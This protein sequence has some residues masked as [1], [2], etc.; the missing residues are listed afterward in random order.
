MRTN[1]WKA[2][3][4]A[5]LGVVCILPFAA[6]V[7]LGQ[8][9]VNLTAGATTVT[10]PDGSVVPMWGYTCGTVALT[11]PGCRPLNL[12]APAAT[13]TTPAGWSPV[14]I[15]VPYV[16]TGTSLTIN[17]T[18][19]LTFTGGGIPTSLVIVGQLGAG[20]G[21]LTQRTTT[22]APDHTNAQQ[23]TWP[24]ADP[25]ALGTPP[26]QGPRVQSFSTE[27]AAGA[28]GVP[29]TWSNLKPGTYLIES[30]THPSI[31]GPMGLYGILVV[32]TAPAGATA[33]TAYP[34]VG[35]TVPAVTYSAEVPLLLSE[36]DPLQNNAVAKAVTLP[37]FSETTVWSGQP[38]GCGNP[39][40]TNSGNCYP[41]AVNY[42]PLYYLFNGV[43]FNKTIATSTNPSLF[44]TLP[45]TGL[46]AGTGTVLVRFVNAGLR[47][48]VPSIVGTQTGVAVAPATTPPSGF[49]LIAEDG[50]PLPGV[51]RVQSEVFLPAG[52]T[53]D[54]MINVPATGAASLPVYDRELSL[55]GNA[56]ARDAGMLAYISVNGA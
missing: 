30:G 25:T 11:G 29:L 14:V 44:P 1:N 43:A 51:P 3:L 23:T 46:T 21:D 50:N 9:T 26:R 38:G 6:V 7:A 45:A 5:A 19:S 28:T 47:M 2:I 4:K 42:T 49:S 53:Y 16:A 39:A 37:G 34:A 27:V 56:T 8:Q 20:L 48:H 10:L 15:T 31:Q 22:L 17:L 41:P 55:S 52:K 35:T 18:N 54:V 13:A 24:I 36:I 33:G 32:T 12:A 40:S